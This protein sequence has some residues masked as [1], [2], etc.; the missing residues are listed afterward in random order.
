MAPVEIDHVFEHPYQ[1][2]SPSHRHFAP[3][4]TRIP[5]FSAL[6]IPYRWMLAESASSIASDQAIGFLPELE[7]RVHELAGFGQTWVQDR[8]NQ[9]A[10]LDTF[11]SAAQ[12][13]KSLAFFYAKR[14]PL[15]DG[16]RRVIVGVGD[17]VGVGPHTEYEY[18]GHGP[19]KSVVWER[20]IRHSIRPD[21]REGFLLPYHDLLGAAVDD[22]TIDLEAM[23]VFAPDDAWDQ[24]AYGTEHVSH[25][26]A[27]ASLIAIERAI[28]A[29]KPHVPG[30]WDSAI[31]WVAS[32][33]G[34]IWKM[35]GPCPG[36]AAALAA[37]G[38]ERASFVAMAISAY[39]GENEDPWPAV[40]QFFRDPSVFGSS[41]GGVDATI[42]KKW[43][44]LKD[45]RRAL[46]KLLSRFDLT[47][48]QA[49]RFYQ[50]TVR[51]KA[52][53]EID[54][55][56][57]IENPYLLYEL[58]RAQT[59]PLGVAEIDRGAF[60]EPIV[61]AQHPMPAP[62]GLEGPIDE[63]RVRAL[64][65][66]ALEQEAAAGHTLAAR[67]TVISTVRDAA[68]APPCPIDADLLDGMSDSFR[69]VIE[70]VELGDGSPA[71]QLRSLHRAGATIR[72]QV[73]K[74]RDA[75]PLSL[76]EDWLSRLT[77][78]LPRGPMDDQE[79]RA[80]EEKVA[81]LE[82]LA[83]NRVSVLVGPAGTGKTTLL[84]AL[85]SS[86]NVRI[87]GVLL[88]APTGKA[89]VRMQEMIGESVG[90]AKTIAQF[91][92]P[93][94]R[95]T[96]ETGRYQPSDGP[97]FN[98][99]RTVII[100]EA[101]MLT[102]EQLA[103]TLD[104]LSGVER[105]I[106]VGDPRQLPPIG[107]G[108]P[109]VDI[110]NWLAPDD[111][112][113]RF[114][115]VGESYAEL[116][117][118]RRGGGVIGDDLVLADWFS[119]QP[120]DPGADVVWEQIAGGVASPRLEVR[121]WEHESELPE[122]IEDVLV[123]ELDLDNG[124]PL[125]FD[126]ELGATE[127][128]GH[129]YFNGKGKSGEGAAAAAE[130]WQILSP[131][132]GSPAGSGQL[133]RFVQRKFRARTLD[134]ARFP[135]G[136]RKIPKPVGPEEIVYGDKV[137]CVRNQRRTNTY[138]ENTGQQYVANGEI[139]IV[140]GEFKRGNWK[141]TGLEVQFSSQRDVVYKFRRGELSGDD[142]AAT[143]ELAYAITVHKSQG[144]E[145]KRTILILPNPCRLLSRELLYTALTRQQDRLVI[146]HQGD[147]ADLHQYAQDGASE[148]ARRLTN[149]LEAPTLVEVGGIYL[150]ENL[151]NRTQRGELVRSKSEVIVAD[152]LHNRGLDYQYERRLPGLDGSSK[153]PDFTIDVAET[154]LKVYW[155]HLGLLNDASYRRRWEDK[156]TWYRDHDILPFEEGGGRAGMLVTSSDDER[157]GIDAQ[158]IAVK[159]EQVFG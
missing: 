51:S 63:R 10:M 152:M 128:N 18:S 134:V 61:A 129:A 139:G 52:G 130:N 110:V 37:F 97:K 150:E 38:L 85:C 108:R 123:A 90:T 144:S 99:A 155:E 148:T 146:L 120:I 53:I 23:T 159:M 112:E 86:P 27:I 50:P 30:D 135:R 9:L 25:D 16:S 21:G 4:H 105:L 12:P 83:R 64:S 56:R 49:E 8:R 80:R 89:R 138:P 26:S 156:L 60:P 154:G 93:S 140:V 32:R 100:D 132:R 43:S 125:A 59:D 45:E 41:A 137:L 98:A 74:R 136:V 67:D 101:S 149:L 119:G 78:H 13:Q 66:W 69:G 70:L 114:P 104:G 14:T 115:R 77:E 17:I 5:P 133:N 62:S 35:R 87:G 76:A 94:H 54:D 106:L 1:A 65:V 157:G 91:L 109:F 28:Q 147:L 46:L 124:N 113:A 11:F 158:A 7:A 75:A 24:F 39:V 111:V 2:T 44:G 19:V 95:F 15:S 103:A 79:Q 31:Q 55:R 82:V 151:I 73:Q 42:A 72:T 57:L 121:Q 84:R 145:F 92:L 131:L 58:D 118:R 102:E 117:V 22:S 153:L 127:Y 143:L 20:A 81:A 126:L 3:A 141:P 96:P 116:T 34:T 47:A 36:L 29:S 88:L 6:C 142:S 48:D 40:D 122:L 33:L 107:A 68:L 71:M